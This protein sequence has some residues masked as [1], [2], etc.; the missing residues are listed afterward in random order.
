MDAELKAMWVSKLR[1]GEIKQGR[2]QLI[3]EEGAMCCV[4]VLGRL[5]GISDDGLRRRA[6]YLGASNEADPLAPLDKC[7]L[8]IDTRQVLAHMNDKPN[9]FLEIADYIEKNL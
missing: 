1:S 7:G 2:E 4:G 6:A 3:D 9:T 8:G 5:L